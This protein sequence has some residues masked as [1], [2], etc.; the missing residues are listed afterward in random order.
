MMAE[1]FRTRMQA[2]IDRSG[3]NHAAFARLA[4]IDR[5][6]L[7]QLLN[8]Q[9]S[10][11]PRADT[12]DA[13]AG[14]CLVSV[15]WLLGRSQQEEMGAQIIEAAL[16]VETHIR[17]PVDDRY[18]NWFREADGTRV[19]TVPVSFPDLLKTEEVIRFEYQGAFTGA[20]A[21]A[22]EAVAARLAVMRRAENDLEVCASL[23]AFT[24]MAF[25]EGTWHG[26]GRQ[27]REDQI[28]YLIKLYEELYPG[29]RVYLYTLTEAYSNPFSVFGRKRVALF[30]GSS[31]LVLTNAAHIRLFN[32]RFDD[33]IKIAVVQPH[34][35]TATMQDILGDIR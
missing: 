31:F 29:L 2:L 28:K 7:S 11:L 14:A 10:R 33:L 34:Q 1:I 15:D 9:G 21:A 23:Q 18:L 4:G 20:D 30:L 13:V 6:T 19:R 27:A 35:F 17:G 8:A 3:L 25:G 26:L 24:T 12:L 32:R 16:K 5:S 22:Y